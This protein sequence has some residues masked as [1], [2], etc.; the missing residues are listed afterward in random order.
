MADSLYLTSIPNMGFWGYGLFVFFVLWF[1]TIPVSIL[2]GWRIV[3]NF[4]E[5]I[6]SLNLFT[7]LGFYFL[8]LVISLVVPIFLCSLIVYFSN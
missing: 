1:I 5:K 8:V 4:K 3:V 7:K 2:I 6:T